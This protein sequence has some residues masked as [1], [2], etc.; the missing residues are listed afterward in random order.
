MEARRE[1][2]C[3][4]EKTPADIHRRNI[5]E[6]AIQTHNGNFTSILAS[7]SDNFPIHQWHELIPQAVL[8]LNLLRQSNVVPNIS[9]YAY[10]HGSFDYNCMPLAYMG[11][12]VQFHIKPNRRKTWDEHAGDGW[13]LI[14]SPDHYRCHW[15]FVKATRAKRI[16]DTVYFKHK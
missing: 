12:A 7:I 16:S 13:Y 10:H 9:A 2:K 15:I 14:T 1:N 3:R 6:W 11:C 5:A 8:T 4:V